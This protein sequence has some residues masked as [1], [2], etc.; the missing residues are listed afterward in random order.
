MVAT[1][2]RDADSE[3]EERDGPEGRPRERAAW[4]TSK[5]ASTT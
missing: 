1:R 5:E 3:E 4:D 2:A